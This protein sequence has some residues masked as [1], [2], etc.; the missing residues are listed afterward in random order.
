MATR[1]AIVDELKR[2]LR[3]EGHTYSRVAH[4]LHLSVASGKR[5]F[6]AR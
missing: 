3:K 1:T 4:T 5:L 2:A 6:F